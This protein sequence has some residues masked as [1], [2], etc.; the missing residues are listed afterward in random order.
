MSTMT[1]TPEISDAVL[2][3][4]KSLRIFSGLTGYSK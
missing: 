4:T 2:E 1:K 3:I